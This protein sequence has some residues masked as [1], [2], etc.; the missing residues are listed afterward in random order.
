[1]ARICENCNKGI[2]WGHRVSH[3]KNRTNRIFKPNLQYTKVM[4]NGKMKRMK[5][6]T[7][8]IKLFRKR[9]KDQVEKAKAEPLSDSHSQSLLSA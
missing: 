5:V 6:C 2:M 9:A 4:V 1:M 3:A 7:N 8:C